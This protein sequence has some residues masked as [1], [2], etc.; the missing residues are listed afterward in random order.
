MTFLGSEMHE[1]DMKKAIR[2]VETI[3]RGCRL[4]TKITA[5]HSAKVPIVKFCF[6][7]PE[8]EADISL[9]NILAQRN[10]ELLLMYSQIDGRVKLLGYTLKLFAKVKIF[11]IQ[12][13]LSFIFSFILFL[14]LYFN[15]FS[16]FT[17]MLYIIFHLVLRSILSYFSSQF[18]SYKKRWIAC[19][20]DNF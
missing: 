17:F 6:K 15:F 19:N 4:I 11:I 3:L 8:I 5:I 16:V 20:A 1:V 14:F 13:I 12:F 7:N 2:S 18:N 9:Y 10:T